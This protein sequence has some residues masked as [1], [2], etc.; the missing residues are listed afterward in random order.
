MFARIRAPHRAAPNDVRPQAPFDEQLA[1]VIR[2]AREVAASA[3]E[4]LRELA[5]QD[6]AARA[7]RPSVSPKAIALAPRLLA[8]TQQQLLS[9]LAMLRTM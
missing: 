2:S 6:S 1:E 7:G 5:V 4:L 8:A 9:V 3:E